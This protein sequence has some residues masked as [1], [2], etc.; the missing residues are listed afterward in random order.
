[1]KPAEGSFMFG[2]PDNLQA[3]L[4]AVQPGTGRVLA[5][6]GG[7]DGK[8]NDFGGFY[9]DEKGDATGI[10]R[11]P[12]GSSFK[13]YTLAAALKAGISLD[14]YWPWIRTICPAVS[15]TGRSAM[16]AHVRATR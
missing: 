14:S 9:Y 8:G 1:M 5:Y 2:Q 13:V 4:V 7:A 6:F 12:P 3:A 10:G 15:A 11:F 16:R